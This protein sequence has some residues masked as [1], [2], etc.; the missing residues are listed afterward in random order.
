MNSALR[1]TV[2]RYHS[3]IRLNQ[4]LQTIPVEMNS[5]RQTPSDDLIQREKETQKYVWQVLLPLHSCR[6][7]V[8]SLEQEQ[9]CRRL[10]PQE[11]LHASMTSY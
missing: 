2:Q 7:Q 4:Y 8:G 6:S 1:E 5:R 10:P 9:D 3:P 11:A